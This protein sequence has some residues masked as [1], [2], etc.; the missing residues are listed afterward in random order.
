MLPLK[1][2]RGRMTG[3]TP[4]FTQVRIWLADQYRNDDMI[5]GYTAR[6][7]PRV[8]KEGEIGFKNRPFVK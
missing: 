4:T 2:F 8:K 1:E 7:S 5:L 3:T 6:N